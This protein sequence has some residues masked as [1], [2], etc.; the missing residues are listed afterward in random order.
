MINTDTMTKII[1]DYLITHPVNV[2]EG[3]HEVYV[4]GDMSVGVSKESVESL[5]LCE[6]NDVLAQG[7]TEVYIFNIFFNSDEYIEVGGAYQ[8][9]GKKFLDV[10]D[11]TTNGIAEL[12]ATWNRLVEA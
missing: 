4:D 2:D 8:R 12:T 11:H 3:V 6:E 10:C 7:I 9:V 1:N 5:G